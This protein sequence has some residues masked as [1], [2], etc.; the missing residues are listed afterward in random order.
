MVMCTKQDVQ[1]IVNKAQEHNDDQFQ[2]IRKERD[3]RVLEIVK[4]EISNE[5]SRFLQYIGFGGLIT[6]GGLFYFFGQQNSNLNALSTDL[7][8]ISVQMTSVEGFMSSGD[9]F[10]TGDGQ[11]LEKNL[12]EY[13]DNKDELIIQRVESGFSEIS[14]QIQEKEL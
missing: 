6:V 14:R 7:S 3:E 2:K 5:K 9:R 12:R 4:S 11:D 8:E 10:T 1:E 13:S